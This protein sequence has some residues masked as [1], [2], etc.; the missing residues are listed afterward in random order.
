V[1]TYRVLVRGKFDR[2][3]EA[4]RAK[5]LADSTDGGLADLE[6]TDA[7]AL[8]YS[9]H[10][11]GFSFRVTVEVTQGHDATQRAHDEAELKAMERLEGEGYPYRAL[12]TTSTCMD[13]IKIRRH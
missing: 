9:P 11:G 13:D 12:T 5:L 3:S 6:F 8:T 4:V 2:P 7:G 10:L 1:P